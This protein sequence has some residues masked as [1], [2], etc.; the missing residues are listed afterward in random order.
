[1]RVKSLT[2]R[3]E[4]LFQIVPVLFRSAVNFYI[5]PSIGNTVLTPIRAIVQSRGHKV[6]MVVL[7]CIFF[8]HTM[9]SIIREDQADHP[10]P[11]IRLA[12]Q[13]TYAPKREQSSS[14]DGL[15]TCFS[16]GTPLFS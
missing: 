3:Q 13:A 2:K 14:V 11:P 8:N 9:T 4:E 1:M 16:L 15:K 7:C 12:P 6:S 5:S 10:P